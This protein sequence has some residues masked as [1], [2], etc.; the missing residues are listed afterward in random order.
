M[1]NRPDP[2]EDPKSLDRIT[3]STAGSRT[4]TNLRNFR[5]ARIAQ[6]KAEIDAGN[7]ESDELLHAALE[8]ML[9]N[10][11]GGEQKNEADS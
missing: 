1:S 5:A 4:P 8:R 7:Y 3:D 9:R 2:I 10:N 6:I 11:D